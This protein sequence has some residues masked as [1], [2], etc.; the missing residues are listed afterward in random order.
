MINGLGVLGWGVGGIEA[1][2]AML[3]EA[4]SM[5]VPQ[6]VGFRFTGELP[7][8]AT[9]TDLVLTVT[10]ILRKVGVV[11][12]FVEYFG[13]GV[14]SL[15]L[16][17]RATLGNMSPEY[18]ATCGF[19]P[20]DD[21]T[22]AYLRLTNRS[23][24]HVALVEAYCKENMLWHEPDEHPTYS[25]VVELDLGDVEPSLAGPRR[26]QDRVPLTSAK[27]SF[28][29]ALDTFGVA[30]PNGSPDKALADTFPASDPTTEQ[31]PGGE[32]EPVEDAVTTHVATVERKSVPVRGEDYALEHG[33]VVIAAITS[34]TNTSNPSV[35]IGAG[36]LAKKAVEKGLKRKPWVKSSL[37]P[38][39]KVVTEYY[40]RAGLEQY[41]DELGFNLVGYGCTTCIGNSGPLPD[42]IGEAITEGELVVCAVLSGNRN[43]EARIHSDVKANYLASPPL[44]VA[45]ALAG[46]MD[47]DLLN[48]PIGE[49]D[50]GPVY[51]HDI[52]PTSAEID[53]TIAKSVDG[54]MFKDA[55]ADV[56]TGDE[57][58]RALDTPSGDLFAWEPGSTYVRLPPYFDGMP[59]DPV[60]VEDLA[61]ARVLVMLGD[62]VT[63]DHISPAG[64]IRPDSP[65]GTYLIEQ[66]VE[67]RAFNSYGARRGNHEVMV[68]GTFAN[69]RLRNQL[70]EGSEGTW[71]V[72]LP[73]GEEG[74]I[75]DIASR[76]RNEGVPTIVLAGKEYG[77][78]S[79]RDWAAKGPNLLGV[80]AVI[81]E[82]Y[83]R[84]HRSNLLMMGI[85]PLQ[86]L[87][88][89]TPASLG[90]TGREEFSISGVKAGE[91]RE[92]TV[93]ADGKEF[94]ARVRLDTPREREYFRH[95]GILPF[96]LRRLLAS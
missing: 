64:A 3:G 89:D 36:L 42:A 88:G 79:S 39:S 46:R 17:D 41:L 73:D 52:W 23:E 80:R 14:P 40:R 96:V 34:C 58:W 30:Y 87:D 28:I 19:F 29:K 82:S 90:L 67:R 7:Q 44:V 60:P 21:V 61:G 65:A 6:V 43:F 5:L 54:A 63:T 2:A 24:E 31:Q 70:V 77:S 83:E 93:R 76:Y 47:I 62:S 4:L 85:L 10:E 38:G 11:G 9:A 16:A 1:E 48:E 49:G 66:G 26:P 35:M 86:F 12:K 74:P 91:A 69:V 20:V 50:D 53:A 68:R 84:I 45:Y 18:G 33:S 75:F 72:H 22:L 95:G 32:P 13:P 94:A 56:F 25:Q 59:R 15:A 92:V 81:A 51:L 57:R 55:Y 8:G 37:A 78:G 27:A 71:T